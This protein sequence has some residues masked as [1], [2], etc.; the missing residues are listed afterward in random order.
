MTK[1]SP[2]FRITHNDRVLGYVSAPTYPLARE[3][4]VKLYGH[5]IEVHL[6]ANCRPYRADR[7]E[8]N[9]DYQAKTNRRYPTPG[10]DARRDAL[11]AEHMAR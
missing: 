11:I 1:L 8:A 3:K 10:F 5:F 2:S 4:A 9:R 7:M 6:A